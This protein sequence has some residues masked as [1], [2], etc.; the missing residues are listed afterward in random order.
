[1]FVWAY[2]RSCQQYVA[3]QQTLVPPDIFRLR[4]R[5]ALAEVVAAIVRQGEAVTEQAVQRLIPTLVPP[6]EH[7]QFTALVLA[8]FVSLHAGNVVRFGIR[9]L[10]YSAWRSARS[11]TQPTAKAKLNAAPSK[12]T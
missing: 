5:Q 10:E 3:I 6:D 11:Q 12:K 1:V 7:A 4:H 9:P 8:E 2:E